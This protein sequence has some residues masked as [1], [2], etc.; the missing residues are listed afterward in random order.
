MGTPDKGLELWQGFPNP[1]FESADMLDIIA[2]DCERAA[3]F[4]RYYAA[5]PD[6]L[7][8]WAARIES[9]V[10]KDSRSIP[11]ESIDRAGR[12]ARAW[13]K[14]IREGVAPC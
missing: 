8:A 9:G 4:I 1:G 6:E 10:C 12:D 7:R 11:A 5:R 3:R 2:S 14:H 13:A